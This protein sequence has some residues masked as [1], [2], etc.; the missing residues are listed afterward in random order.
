VADGLTVADRR[1]VLAR[2]EQ[3]Q[4]ELGL[5][6]SWLTNLDADKAAILLE[7]AHRCLGAAAWSLE[8]P[9]R[10]RPEGWLGGADRAGP[11]S[12]PGR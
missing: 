12:P 10:L 9:L 6:S 2:L 5:I 3:L 4:A 11:G 8:P 1:Q 7:D